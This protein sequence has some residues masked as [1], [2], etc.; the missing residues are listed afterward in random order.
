MRQGLQWLPSSTAGKQAPVTLQG[1]SKKPV[2]LSSG[3]TLSGTSLA[4][5]LV[6]VA[7]L[8][9]SQPVLSKHLGEPTDSG[10]AKSGLAEALLSG[11]VSDTAL[12]LV[13]TAVAQRWSTEDDLAYAIR[14]LARLALLV[15]AE[16]NDEAGEVEEQLFR[17]SRILDGKTRTVFAVQENLQPAGI[18]QQAEDSPALRRQSEVSDRYF[19]G[20]G[21]IPVTR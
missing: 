12:E 6:S 17:F 18:T 11:K 8:L 1:L 14:Y 13:K 7:K 5:D 19:R 16:R 2:Y 10:E 21:A 15:R 9:V 3:A 4:D 20:A